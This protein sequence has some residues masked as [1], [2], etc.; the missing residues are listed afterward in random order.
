[1][2][3]RLVDWGKKY[4]SSGGKKVLI[5]SVAQAL[6]TYVMSVFKLPMSVCDD[7]MKMMRSYWWGVENGKHKT[8]WVAWDKMILPKNLGGLGFRDMRLFNQALLARQAW[9]LIDRPDSLCARLIKAK[10]YRWGN[11]VDTVFWGNP[12]AVWKGIE[13]GLELLKKGIIWRIGNG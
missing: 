7:L 8:H 1:M 3:K 5:K 2:S 4:I 11:L 10:Y 13:H 12:S 9:R 6:P